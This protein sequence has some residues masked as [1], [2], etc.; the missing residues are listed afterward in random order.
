MPLVAL[1]MACSSDSY[2]TGD[3]SLSYMV[4]DFV[5]AETDASAKVVSIVTDRD[6]RLWLTRSVKL[7]WA[8]KPDTAYRSLIYYNKVKDGNGQYVAEPVGATQVLTPAV[9]ATADIKGGMKTDPVVFESAWKSHNGKYINLDLSVKTGTVDGEYGQQTVEKLFTLT[10][11]V[12]YIGI[13]LIAHRRHAPCAPHAVSRP[14]ISARILFG[15]ALHEHPHG[16]YPHRAVGRRRGA[17]QHCHLRRS[18]CQD[19]WF[20]TGDR[21]ATT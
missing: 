6:E 14:G 18:G 13:A 2:D 21:L 20:L 12:R 19:I 10:N 17:G 3:G 15:Q 11:Y 1:L 5:E 7:D 9:T 16:V 8:E 4:A